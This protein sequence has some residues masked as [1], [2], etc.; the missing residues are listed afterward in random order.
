MSPLAESYISAENVN[1]AELF[2]PLHPKTCHRCWLVQLGE[3]A[4]P[5]EIFEEYAYFSSYSDSW[6]KHAKFYV[7]SV[8][9]RFGLTSDSRV[10]EI[11]SN[12][13]YLL[14][15]FQ[16]YSIPVLGVEPARNVAEVAIRKKIPTVVAFFD[17]QTAEHLFSDYGPADLIIANNVLAQ[18]PNLHGFVSGLRTLLKPDGVVT[19]EFPHLCSLLREV[20]FD[21]IYHEHFSYFSFYTVEQLFARHDLRVFDVEKLLTH[22]GSLRVYV[23][24]SQA[25]RAETDRVASLRAEEVREGITCPETYGT[26]EN[27]VRAIK[28]ELLKLLISVKDQGKKIAGYGAPGKGNTLLNYCGIHT[29]LLD[30]TVDRNLYKQGKYLPG[31]RI[32]VFPPQHL[33]KTQPDMI[34]ILPWNLRAEIFPQLRSVCSWGPQFVTAIPE[35]KVYS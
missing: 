2:Y 33:A 13:G 29:D 5:P 14:Q 34:F 12:D 31:V 3:Y 15:H 9:T 30:Y 11:A 35:L 16:P 4:S 19:L 20:Q 1:S 22:G 25:D 21:T 23:C 26:F 27:K 24:H 8:I 32:P 10:F 17:E 18:V 7:D 28:R 6:V